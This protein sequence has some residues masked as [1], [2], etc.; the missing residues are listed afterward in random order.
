[1]NFNLI[2]T[3]LTSGAITTVIALIITIFQCSVTASGSYV[4]TA[5]W[6][7][8]EYLG[9]LAAG[10]QITALILKTFQGGTAMESLGKPSVIVSR[11]GE[12]GTVT[13]AQVNSGWH[14]DMR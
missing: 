11:S 9:Y 10:L 12:K 5:P 13:P 6:V 3:L 2:R 7:P 14:K 8:M 1:M 4:C